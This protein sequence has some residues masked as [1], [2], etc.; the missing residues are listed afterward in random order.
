VPSCPSCLLM[1]VKTLT[2]TAKVHEGISTLPASL[3][4]SAIQKVA[5]CFFAL[6][7]QFFVATLY[8]TRRVGLRLRFAARWATIGKTWLAGP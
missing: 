1:F 2:M 3:G 6:L 5:H 8:G 4:I 7:I